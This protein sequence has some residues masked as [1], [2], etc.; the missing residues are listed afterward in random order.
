MAESDI[1]IVD[2]TDNEVMTV[3]MSEVDLVTGLNTNI[4]DP[5]NDDILIY[6]DGVWINSTVSILVD[7]YAVHSEAVTPVNQL[8]SAKFET[9][10]PYRAETLQVFLNGLKIH[11]S[12]ITQHSD[13]QFSLPINVTTEDV[14]EVAYIKK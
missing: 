1:I 4:T 7:T 13:T 8:P 14:I 5:K 2:Q 12:E 10:N 6:K 9:V 3:E 11:E